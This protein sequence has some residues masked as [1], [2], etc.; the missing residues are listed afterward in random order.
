MKTEVLS[1]PKFR[2]GGQ[3]GDDV[4]LVL[5][6]VVHGVFDGATDA[7]G[8][9][10]DGMGAGRLAALAVAGS[11]A[12]LMADPAARQL[13]MADILA[14]ISADLAAA[15]GP[16]GLAIP[17]STTMAVAVDC[18]PD[19]RFLVLGDTGIRLNGTE[20]LRH[21]KIIDDVST[22]ARVQVFRAL[23]PF[24]PGIDATERL[25]RD[26]ALL[27]LDHAVAQG[28]LTPDHAAEIIARTGD[29]TGL[30]TAAAE[31]EAFL[32]GGIKGQFLLAN[33][34]DH[35]LGFDTL[36]GTLPACG[37]WIDQS[38]PKSAVASIE[39]FTDGYPDIPAGMSVADWEAA[40]FAAED[41][42]YH[43]IGRFAS[44]KGSTADQF[45]DDR[46]VLILS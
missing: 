44:V 39:I 6:G 14:R 42:D 11:V 9:V 25:A 20:V 37:Q 12:R 26:T 1:V 46:T 24:H 4:P 13:A 35:P 38:R 33:Q 40:F 45:F 3:Y 7:L 34:P 30:T 28:I 17:P 5:P 27:G 29:E 15:T 32:R 36:N 22:A 23:Q 2:A 19:W 16:L 21:E 18:G 8:T 31:V 10:I 41:S 43:K